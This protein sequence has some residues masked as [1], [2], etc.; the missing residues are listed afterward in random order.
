[1]ILVLVQ[2]TAGVASAQS[3]DRCS[4]C[5]RKLPDA[6]L[7]APAELVAQSAHRDPAISCPACHGGD[8]SE[9]TVRAHSS[10]DF[11]PRPPRK[12]VPALCG[13][14]H[15]DAPFIR[16]YN[17]TLPIDQ[18]ALFKTSVHGQL[19]E[20]GDG[21]V[22][23]CTSC[24]GTHDVARAADPRSRVYPTRV[25]A[26]CAGCHADAALM[27]R[28]G[29]RSDQ[30]ALWSGSVHGNGVSAGNLAAPTCTSCH[31]SHGASPPAVSSI[32]RVCGRCHSE[33]LERFLES[34]H[35]RPFAQLGF[36]ECEQCHGNHAVGR[37]TEALLGLGPQAICAKCHAQG[38]KAS[39]AIRDLS[40]MVGR[41]HA[42]ADAARGAAADAARVGY[43]S[44]ETG[45]AL[46]ELHTAEIRVANVLH[47]FDAEKLRRASES[48]SAAAERAT[49]SVDRSHGER[50][51]Q[52]RGYLLFA[53]LC[54]LHLV[55]LVLKMRTL[56]L[57]RAEPDA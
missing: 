12:G 1:M 43:L 27:G 39:R 17:A 3:V 6:R 42:S 31:G 37:A 51:A 22:A 45:V 24:H 36:P 44:A 53:A 23:V 4:P 38:Q 2:A 52:K 18:L 20:K 19:L 8:R 32:A 41:A 13:G 10:A 47:S 25:G 11:N 40:E 50:R 33:Q 28:Y 29:I 56:P 54:L 46:D 35:A 14:C 15:S 55:L 48:V 9:P 7:R 49:R 5:H 26:T 21:A 34:P 16:R 57:T 30:H